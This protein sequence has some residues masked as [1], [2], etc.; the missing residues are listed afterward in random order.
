MSGFQAYCGAQPVSVFASRSLAA[1]SPSL[2]VSLVCSADGFCLRCCVCRE[3]GETLQETVG[4]DRHTCT[5]DSIE[6]D[7]DS[8]VS[9]ACP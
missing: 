5:C 3:E 1:H 8:R 7:N 4:C 6:K 2:G 9:Q